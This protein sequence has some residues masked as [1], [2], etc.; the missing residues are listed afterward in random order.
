MTDFEVVDTVEFPA[1]GSD[2]TPA[3]K[4]R[5]F[6]FKTYSPE[7]FRSVVVTVYCVFLLGAPCGPMGKSQRGQ[8]VVPLRNLRGGRQDSLPIFIQEGLPLTSNFIQRGPTRIPSPNIYFRPTMIPHTPQFSWYMYKNKPSYYTCRL[9]AK[10]S[11]VTKFF[12]GILIFLGGQAP[13]T[14]HQGF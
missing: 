7:A 3:H 12:P 8:T 1:N 11:K 10:A 14:L 2:C 6:T 5:D 13:H 9:T 4:Y